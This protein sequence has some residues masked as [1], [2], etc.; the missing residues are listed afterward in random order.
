MKLIKLPTALLLIIGLSASINA[1]ILDEIEKSAPYFFSDLFDHELYNIDYVN[2][3]D[4]DKNQEM[5]QDLTNKESTEEQIKRLKRRKQNCVKKRYFHKI[6]KYKEDLSRFD[7][8]T[9]IPGLLKS[10]ING[11]TASGAAH[12]VATS[13][14]SPV[15][16]G[17]GAFLLS[18]LS[19]GVDAY[20]DPTVAGERKK[21]DILC[22]RLIYEIDNE[23][24]N[25]IEESYLKAR[26]GLSLKQ[27]KTIEE[28]LLKERSAHAHHR[29]RGLKSFVEG[30]IDLPQKALMVPLNFEKVKN[31]EYSDPNV[32]EAFNKAREEFLDK[33]FPSLLTSTGVPTPSTD[34]TDGKLIL[35]A[36]YYPRTLRERFRVIIGNICDYSYK[37]AA[38]QSNAV[39]NRAIIFQ[40][41]PGA[42]K[43]QAAKLIAEQCGLPY[44]HMTIHGELDHDA[45]WGKARGDFS[46]GQPGAIV[47][48]FL[49]K[50]NNKKTAKNAILIFDDIDR[51]QADDVLA[52]LMK[53]TDTTSMQSF[54]SRYFDVEIDMKDF[55]V[56]LTINSDWYNNKTYAALRSRADFVV[57]PDAQN[58]ELKGVL[59]K[60]L[61]PLDFQLS[62]HYRGEREKC[63]AVRSEIADFI[64]DH[65]DIDDNR[66]RTS[67]AKTLL[68]YPRAEWDR[69]A[70][71]HGW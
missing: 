70:E 54:I 42:G 35:D 56:I 16:S 58:P 3:Y 69:I 18:A 29:Q 33:L 40:G 71:S 34:N 30:V 53:L 67:R 1:S 44:D 51:S 45:I 39:E 19:F 48:A 12:I 41:K 6:N 22:N 52:F 59:K 61:S 47:S 8:Q 26:E 63:D 5:G 55:L 2:K 38:G 11:M 50:N 49:K 60:A 13:S 68:R 66:Q 36:D 37:S 20:F 4:E 43:S 10:G 17:G 28:V 32:T 7:P 15:L 46:D 9:I 25:D 23:A 24:I 57:F 14:V 31:L 64:I 27:R 62:I 65:H 21:A